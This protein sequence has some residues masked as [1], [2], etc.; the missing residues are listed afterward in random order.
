MQAQE[1]FEKLQEKFGNDIVDFAD[2]PPSDPF[3]VVNKEKIV[4][5]ALFL[6]DE[7]GLK[8]DYMSCL[9]GVQNKDNT[10]TVVYHLY[11][12]YIKHRITLKAHL[13]EENP[14]IDTVEK[15]WRSA[16]WHEREAY[17]MFGIIFEGHHNLIRILT[18]YDWEDYPLRKDYK[19]P[20][21]YHGIKVPY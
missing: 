2:A 3:I 19:A 8:F 21:E 15:V 11:S 1:I 16:D 5:I 12:I 20:D 17:D 14:K 6:R 10:F 9:S 4:D 13:G 18:P 7:D